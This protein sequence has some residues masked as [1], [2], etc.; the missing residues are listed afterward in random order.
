[1]AHI[2]DHA[3]IRTVLGERGVGDLRQR[4]ERL[5]EQQSIKAVVRLCR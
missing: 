2:S 5:G 1:V 4:T 3:R